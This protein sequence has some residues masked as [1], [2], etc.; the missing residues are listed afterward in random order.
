MNKSE[1]KQLIDQLTEKFNNYSFFYFADDSSLNVAAI[2]QLR[3][4][5]FEKGIPY[6]VAKNTLIIKALEASNKNAEEIFGSLKG[7]TAILYSDTANAPAKLLKEFRK[8]GD[9]PI[10]KSAFLDN[11]I[12][13]GDNQ[14]SV[15]AS[16]KSRNE[17]IGDIIG[18]LQSPI[19]TVIGA[20]ENKDA[21]SGKTEEVAPVAETAETAPVADATAPD[22]AD[23]AA[24]ITN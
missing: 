13:I 8:D 9:R 10:L 21:A 12:Y 2:S 5:C 15:L 6:K 20:L 16:L 24:D 19:Q 22:A 3:R 23:N 1:K 7:S 4:M 18:L 11:E 17:L 14:L